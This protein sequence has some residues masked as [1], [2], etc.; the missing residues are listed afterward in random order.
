EKNIGF[1]IAVSFLLIIIFINIFGLIIYFKLPSLKIKEVKKVQPHYQ[2]QTVPSVS[3]FSK[4][5][6]DPGFKQMKSYPSLEGEPKGKV[7]PF[8]P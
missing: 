2:G 5:I 4:I 3:N 1:Y 6:E 8:T 7:N